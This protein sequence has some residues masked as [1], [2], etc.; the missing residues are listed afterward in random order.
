MRI[1]V[2]EDRHVRGLEP[3]TLT[4]PAADL[5]C[6][7][8]TLGQ[9]HARYFAA[10]TVGHFCRPA[11]AELIRS[12][13]PDAGVND[14]YWLRSGPTVVVNARWLPPAAKSATNP[15]ADGPY[16]GTAGGQVAFAVLDTARLP[17]V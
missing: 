17:A 11:V 5:L 3:L 15:L 1:Y 8:T 14:A 2:Y 10:G 13:D 16:M 6:G 12:R 9:K 4:R 7:L